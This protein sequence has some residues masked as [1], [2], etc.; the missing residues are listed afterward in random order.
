MGFHLPTLQTVHALS[1][2]AEDEANYGFTAVVGDGFGSARSRA[3]RRCV[4]S[5]GLNS[6]P[7][8]DAAGSPLYN[9]HPAADAEPVRQIYKGEPAA[10]SD[11]TRAAPVRE[12]KLSR[13]LTDAARMCDCIWYARSCGDEQS[14]PRTSH[15]SDESKTAEA[16]ENDG[17]RGG[18]ATNLRNDAAA[19]RPT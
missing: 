19:R 4:L 8:A 3:L 15:E 2:S 16:E 17:R 18:N 13:S 9:S 12:R 5:N 6:H 10:S 1:Y 11:A 7:A 14:A